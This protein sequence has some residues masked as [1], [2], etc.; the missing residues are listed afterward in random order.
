MLFIYFI[1]LFIAPQ[2]WIEPFVGLRVDLIIYPLWIIALFM[3]GKFN[4]FFDFNKQD[5]FF[6]AMVLWIIITIVINSKNSMSNTIIFEYIKWFILYRLVSL[7]ID[8]DDAFYSAIKKIIFIVYIVV[9]QAI[10]HKLSDNG[11]GWAGQPLGWVD[12]SVLDAGGTGRTLWVNIFDGPGVFCVMF[13]LILPFLLQYLDK[14]Y[15][16]KTKFI[17]LVMLLPL[18]FA[19]WTT[20]SRGGFLAT[21]AILGSYFMSRLKVSFMTMLKVGG[22]LVLVF[23]MAPSHLTAVKDD[24]NSAQHRVDMWQEGVEMLEQNPVFGIGKGNF[25]PY[26]GKLIA[27]NSAI[28]IMGEMGGPGFFLWLAM[29]Y[30][31]FKSLF[32]VIE[33]SKDPRLI[34][35][36]KGVSISIIGYL[37]SSFFVTLEYETLYVLLALPRALVQ[38]SKVEAEFESKDFVMVVG[39][40]I[41]FYLVLKVFVRMY[42]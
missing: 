3:T 24:N 28:E 6:L 12:Q 19:I 32:I 29:L 20:G 37:V 1:A 42:Y 22:A 26:T 14:G 15:S 34:S 8:S 38:N 39:I 4:D 25:A 9:I 17:S 41:G 18:F 10:Q 11:I 23:A 30:M 5:A 40:M 13:T 21:L 36:S 35:Y 16:A 27:H 7:T 33:N 2:L 31:A